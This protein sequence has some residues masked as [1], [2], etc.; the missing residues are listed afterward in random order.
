MS[1]SVGHKPHGA[2]Q[3]PAWAWLDTAITPPIRLLLSL[4]CCYFLSETSP[5]FKVWLF[6]LL[7]DG[8]IKLDGRRVDIQGRE[9]RRR[10]ERKRM[11]NDKCASEQEGDEGQGQKREGQHG[12]TT[13]D[14][15]KYRQ[16][17]LGLRW[18]VAQGLLWPA[19][20]RCI[21]SLWILQELILLCEAVPSNCQTRLALEGR[22]IRRQP[23]AHSI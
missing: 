20:R 15:R 4:L 9:E 12:C 2:T 21:C 8:V 6:G 22:R 18:A 19:T 10:G 7:E 5:F 3:S 1:A 16:D 14:I 11:R 23:Q 17:F 13:A